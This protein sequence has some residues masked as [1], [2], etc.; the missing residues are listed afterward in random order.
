[1]SGEPPK[2]GTSQIAAAYVAAFAQ[3]GSAI[4]DAT[5]PHLKSKY[6]DLPSVIAAIKPALTE[7]GLAFTQIPRANPDG[8]EI[9]TILHHT[10]GETMD[11]GSL[12]VPSAKKDAQGFGSAMTYARRYALVSAFGVPTED[13]DGHAAS[14]G[15]KAPPAKREKAPANEPARMPDA[16][17]N[18]LVQAAKAAGV[19]PD[20]LKKTYKVDD[21]R[22]LSS[23]QYGAA[24]ERL[25]DKIA[26]KAK[27]E[28]NTAASDELGNG[29]E[30][31]F[32][33]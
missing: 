11:L 8:A 25:K 4:K 19:G 6:A 27:E 20:V 9:L 33:S 24:M 17:Y 15:S 1:M 22:H 23:D 18:E 21:L 5:N 12:F 10:S 3:I 30:D 16:Q 32:A 31:Y 26:E 29:D 28:T 2:N 7:H 13:D 14:S